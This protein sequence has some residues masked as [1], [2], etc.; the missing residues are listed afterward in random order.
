MVDFSLTEQQQAVRKTSREFARNETEP[1][2]RHHEVTGEWPEEVWQKAVDAGLIGVSIPEEVV[3]GWGIK[4]SIFAE[5]FP[6]AMQIYSGYGSTHDYPVERQ[7]R[8]PKRYQIGERTSGIQR[9]SIAK[10]LLDR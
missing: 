9:D 8:H 6:D 10:E 4:A 1:V 2:A 5:E 3:P 7:Y